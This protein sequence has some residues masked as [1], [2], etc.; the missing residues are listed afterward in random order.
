MERAVGALVGAGLGVRE[1]TPARATLEDVF[2]E[3]TRAEAEER[4]EEGPEEEDE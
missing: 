1:A 4:D 2:A 3:L